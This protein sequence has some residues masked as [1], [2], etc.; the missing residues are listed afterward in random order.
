MP[1]SQ[2]RSTEGELKFSRCPFL[3]CPHLS[4]KVQK[5]GIVFAMSWNTQW[6][7]CWASLCSPL[8]KEGSR[9]WRND[10]GL[11][12]RTKAL[13]LAPNP[14]YRGLG[15]LFASVKVRVCDLVWCVVTCPLSSLARHTSPL[16]IWPRRVS[17]ACPRGSHPGPAPRQGTQ[18]CDVPSGPAAHHPDSR[19]LPFPLPHHPRTCLKLQPHLVT[20]SFLCC[21]AIPPP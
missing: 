4:I 7:L 10:P 13:R 5:G 12:P 8:P 9:A 18:G 14:T 1:P 19:F 21:P 15:P 2:P 17:G 11:S 6:G 16:P 3:P 20:N